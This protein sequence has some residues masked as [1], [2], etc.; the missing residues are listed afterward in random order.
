[1]EIANAASSLRT[2]DRNRD[3]QLTPE[4]LRFELAPAGTALALAN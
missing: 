3:G 1:M 2:L 4:E